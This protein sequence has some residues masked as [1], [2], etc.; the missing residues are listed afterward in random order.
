MFD[1]ILAKI[2]VRNVPNLSKEFFYL[3]MQPSM[4]RKC[5]F[6]ALLGAEGALFLLLKY[7]SQHCP[8]GFGR[9]DADNYHT[10]PLF[11]RMR[12]TSPSAS[13]T[14]A[15]SLSTIL[16]MPRHSPTAIACG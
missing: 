15:S 4:L 16:D 12:A 8:N 9:L 13:A 7:G 11:M 1:E 6:G 14:K 3:F 10:F 5:A 2:E